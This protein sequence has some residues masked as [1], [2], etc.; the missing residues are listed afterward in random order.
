MQVQYQTEFLIEEL[1][2]L[3]PNTLRRK[4]TFI[5]IVLVIYA[6][7]YYLISIFTHYL[8][9]PEL[10][11]IVVAPSFGILLLFLYRLKDG[12]KGSIEPIEFVIFSW[13]EAKNSFLQPSIF[14]QSMAIF[15]AIELS[16][17][18]LII[19]VHGSLW[20]RPFLIL[21][22]SLVGI[23]IALTPGFLEGLISTELKVRYL[24]NEG[25]RKSAKNAGFAFLVTELVIVLLGLFLGLI[26][27]VKTTNLTSNLITGS[28]AGLIGGLWLGV[29]L[30]V[31]FGG[32][33]CTKHIAAR[34]FLYFGGAA[35]WNY[36]RFLNYCTERSLLQR[37]GGRYRFIHKLLQKHFAAMP[38]RGRRGSPAFNTWMDRYLRKQS[39]QT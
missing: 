31:E 13:K 19:N 30:A 6:F 11:S 27:T 18:S 15:I 7:T 22:C 34:L 20:Q 14:L 24:P 23:L 1:P 32:G 35:P 9:N 28:L 4:L 8:L 3:T 12:V 36:A 39:D 33:A 17:I 37:V 10:H 21:I 25:I 29:A 2:Y 16:A 38:F 26:F 5:F